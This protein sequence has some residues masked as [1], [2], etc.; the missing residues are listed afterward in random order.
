VGLGPN[1]EVETTCAKIVRGVTIRT[2]Q[3]PFEAWAR[4]LYEDL[5]AYARS[6]VQ[7]QEMLAQLIR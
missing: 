3:V 6:S 4:A 5:H 7:A 1:G 2:E